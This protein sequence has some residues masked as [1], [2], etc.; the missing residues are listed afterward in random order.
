MQLSSI[1]YFVFLPAK[2]NGKQTNSPYAPTA[3]AINGTCT[4]KIRLK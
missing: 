2:S 4:T 1:N 3:I